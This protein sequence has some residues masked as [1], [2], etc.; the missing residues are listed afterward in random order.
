MAKLVLTPIDPRLKTSVPSVLDST[1]K[2]RF[3]IGR[4][5]DSDFVLP[6]HEAVSR[7]H[8][9]IKW[10]DNGWSITDVSRNGTFLNGKRL[11]L[12]TPVELSGLGDKVYCSA[13]VGFV[14]E[15]ATEDEEL[16][17]EIPEPDNE[18]TRNLTIEAALERQ[19]KQIE[20]IQKLNSDRRDSWIDDVR[21]FVDALNHVPLI[22]LIIYGGL[23]LAGLA[24]W[25]LLSGAL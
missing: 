5:H 10:T 3:D 25:L 14:V 2:S 17:F 21:Q 7:Q 1:L 24:L 15:S 13:E 18:P 16:E 23:V 8:C 12:N 6:D 19:R 11:T 9:L 22:R 4:A 20:E